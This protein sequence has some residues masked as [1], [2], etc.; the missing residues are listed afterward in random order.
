M[1]SSRSSCVIRQPSESV[2]IAKSHESSFAV[3]A[4]PDQN[5]ICRFIRYVHCMLFFKRLK[6]ES[7]PYELFPA[8]QPL[9]VHVVE[10][11]GAVLFRMA[12]V[13]AAHPHRGRVALRKA[14]EL[15]FCELPD[16][17][18]LHHHRISV[19]EN[20][21]EAVVLIA[22][23]GHDA[24]RRDHPLA[25]Q[26]PG[27]EDLFDRLGIGRIGPVFAREDA[28]QVFQFR[29]LYLQLPVVVASEGDLDVEE[30]EQSHKSIYFIT[31]QAVLQFDP[32]I[33]ATLSL[34]HIAV[35]RFFVCC[36]SFI[37]G[38]IKPA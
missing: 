33:F 21:Y 14:E 12:A 15:A 36:S 1:A 3:R 30:V 24:E 37:P 20:V 6:C 7:H 28:V 18:F 27:Q 9:V 35:F 4:L 26:V 31:V 23:G 19:A 29:T 13:L 22:A 2:M 5:T 11:V 16:C 8:K 32:V 34:L 38:R 25:R 10:T 17:S